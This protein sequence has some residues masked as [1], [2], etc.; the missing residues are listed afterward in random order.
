M[1]TF[2]VDAHKRTRAVVAV[3][4]LGRWPGV[5]TTCGTTT[6]DHRALISWAERLGPQQT[7]AVEDCRHLSRRLKADMLAVGERIVRALRSR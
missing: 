2:G 7:W 5:F 3:D 4:E 6:A 1:I